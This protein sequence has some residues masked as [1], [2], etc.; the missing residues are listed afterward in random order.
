MYS[1]EAC[2]ALAVPIY[3][4]IMAMSI[5]NIKSVLVGNFRHLDGWTEPYFGV[6]KMMMVSDF[7]RQY[8]F[9]SLVHSSTPI[10]LGFNLKKRL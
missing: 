10:F 6:W 1:E 5:V 8:L 2:E 4:E 3:N 9:G 7:G